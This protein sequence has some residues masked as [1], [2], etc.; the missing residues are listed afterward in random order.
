MGNR[1]DWMLPADEPIL[2]YLSGESSEYA[3]LIADGLGMHH[4]YVDARCRTL[5]EYGLVETTDG[6]G[7]VYRLTER[8]ERYLSGEL[9]P[10]ELSGERDP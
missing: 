2:E 9:E 7:V 8:G 3:P 5:A 10:S 6:G 1:P 4:R